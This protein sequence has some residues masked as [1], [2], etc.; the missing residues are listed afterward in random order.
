VESIIAEAGMP[1]G[2]YA[3][4]FATHAQVAEMIASPLLQGVSITGSER[5]GRII[6]GLAGSN[7]KKCVLELGGSDP[8]IVLPDADIEAAAS[9]A[10]TGRFW[11]AGQACTSSKRTI[12]TEP[13]WDAFV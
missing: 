10:A 12:V 9:A 7:L 2:G 1:P 3:N 5:A 4:V 6:G 11:N 13:V 8:L